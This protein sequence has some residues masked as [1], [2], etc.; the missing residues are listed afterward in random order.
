MNCLGIGTATP[1]VLKNSG[2]WALQFFVRIDQKRVG[3]LEFERQSAHAQFRRDRLRKIV[4]ERNLFHA[5]EIAFGDPYIRVIV[6]AVRDIEIGNIVILSRAGDNRDIGPSFIAG[7]EV[8]IGEFPGHG[9]QIGI[10]VRENRI[11]TDDVSKG[12]GHEDVERESLPLKDI[13]QAARDGRIDRTFID[14]VAHIHSL[15]ELDVRRGNAAVSGEERRDAHLVKSLEFQGKERTARRTFHRVT[16]AG[17][18][19]DH[20]RHGFE[21]GYLVV[22][23]GKDEIGLPF[24]VFTF[25]IAGEKAK[26]PHP[27]ISSPRRYPAYPRHRPNPLLQRCRSGRNYCAGRRPSKE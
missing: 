2:S 23:P 8:A 25:D 1:P 6:G 14:E 20:A 11:E 16:C 3:C 4:R 19:I 26:V 22:H 18:I 15:L 7:I 9:R 5:D 21:F 12:V 27:A 13:T 17:D 24:E 10:T